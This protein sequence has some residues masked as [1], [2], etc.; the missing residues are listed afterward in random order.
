MGAQA[1]GS[2]RR[3]DRAL[4]RR[5]RLGARNRALRRRGIADH[6]GQ[7]VGAPAIAFV[8]SSGGQG[9][10]VFAATFA[11][12]SDWDAPTPLSAAGK[13]VSWADLIERETVATSSDGRALAVWSEPNSDGTF[14]LM[15]SRYDPDIGWGAPR[16]VE[17]GG[18]FTHESAFG[19][20]DGWFVG[21]VNGFVDGS[22]I[23]SAAFREF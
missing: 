8:S 15:A 16:T 14:W 4:R 6:P 2:E 7:S 5:E 19:V 10:R 3:D 22:E 12:A 23:E 20:K 17:F 21:Y 13:D 1:R 11:P 9:Q 18:P